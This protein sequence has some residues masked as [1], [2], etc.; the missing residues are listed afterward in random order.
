M[1]VHDPAWMISELDKEI[2]AFESAKARHQREG[3]EKGVAAGAG[4]IEGLRL[5]RSLAEELD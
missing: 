3:N 1:A 5:A 2:A 4:V